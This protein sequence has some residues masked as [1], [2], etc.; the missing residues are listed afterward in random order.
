MSAPVLSFIHELSFADLPE[1]VVAQS[2]RCLLDLIGVAAAGSSTRL[3]RIIG[4]H[5]VRHYGAGNGGARL[6]F[7]GRRASPPGAALAG[8]ATIDSFDAHDGHPL[9]KGHSGV[10]VLPAILALI[11]DGIEADGRAIL[12]DVV[13]GYEIATRA[14]IALHAMASDYH[15]SGAWNALACAAIGAR[16]LGL[17]AARTREALGVAEYHGPRS[18]MMRCIDHPTMVKDG[19]GWGALAGLSAA[20]LA[21]DGFTGAPALTVEGPEAESQWADLGT[22]WRILEQYFKPY[23]VCR[24]A[25]PAVEAALNLQ[26]RSGLTARDIERIEVVTFHQAARLAV[27]APRTTEEAQYSLPFPVAAALVKGAIGAAEIRGAGLEDPDVLAL[28]QAIALTESEAYNARFPA[29]RWAHVV[30]HLADGTTIRSEP[31]TA[32]GDPENPLA[33]GELAAKY[34]ALAIPVVGPGRSARIEA[35]VAGLDS[36][37]KA[38]ADLLTGLLSPLASDSVSTQTVPGAA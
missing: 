3:S 30:F 36:D 35:A 34:R 18:P 37:E 15:T 13:L 20:Y 1:P 21:A 26:R 4:D 28:S 6:L 17:D 25:Q 11:D 32:R 31:A 38:A 33:E 5:V 12:T 14:G 8:A 23:P 19:S 2:K 22:R 9:T 16:L 24:W 10:A 7:D 27:R 29:E